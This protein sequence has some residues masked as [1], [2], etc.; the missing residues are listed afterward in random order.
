MA[1]QVFAHLFRSI[2]VSPLP[3]LSQVDL[4]DLPGLSTAVVTWWMVSS[5]EGTFANY[6]AAFRSRSPLGD[7]SLSVVQEVLAHELVA[8][9]RLYPVGG[10]QENKL[11]SD[12]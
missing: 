11:R 1:I 12:I 2:Q 10:Q 3:Y 8:L 9:V 7:E 5:V 6:S 4:G